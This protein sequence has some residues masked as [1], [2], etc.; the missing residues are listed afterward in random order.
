MTCAAIRG[1]MSQGERG[2]GQRDQ[3]GGGRYAG[4]VRGLGQEGTGGGAGEGG[5][6]L[7]GEEHG[8]DP[9]E[10]RVGDDPLHGGLRDHQGHGAEHADGYRGGQR[11]GQ[12]R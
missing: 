10:D 2:R 8:A 6:R 1:T 7:A 5:G 4:E 9:A 3:A 12:R 11:G